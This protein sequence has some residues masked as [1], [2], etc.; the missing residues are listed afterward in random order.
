M[1]VFAKADVDA[2]DMKAAAGKVSDALESA[3][4]STSRGSARRIA[5]ALEGARANVL[6]PGMDRAYGAAINTISLG[7]FLLGIYGNAA[8]EM[9]D[10]QA[11]IQSDLGDE[12][13]RRTPWSM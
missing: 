9:A 5:T 13:G 7:R 12:M 2:D 6:S 10:S 3:L 4:V 1:S 8:G 11:A